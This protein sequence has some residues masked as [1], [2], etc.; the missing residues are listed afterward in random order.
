MARVRALGS[1]FAFLLRLTALLLGLGLIIVVQRPGGTNPP[2]GCS[3]YCSCVSMLTA[4]SGAHAGDP[5]E[6]ATGSLEWSQTD[7]SV[8]G[9]IP[10]VFRR[11]HRTKDFSAGPFGP[12]TCTNWD[13]FIIRAVNAPWG[14]HVVS[15]GNRHALFMTQQS[16]GMGNTW[17]TCGGQAAY[18]GAKLVVNGTT[19]AGTLTFPSGT[20]FTFAENG[21]L[22]SVRN[23]FGHGV[24]VGRN[25]DGYVTS[26]SNTLNSW[27]INVTYGANGLVSSVS[28]VPLGRT[29]HYTYGAYDCLET[30]QDVNGGVTSHVWVE[31][32]WG[33]GGSG[34]F[35][36]YGLTRVT[37]PRG[38]VI[39][40]NTYAD[41]RVVSQELANGGEYQ[42]QYLT[43]AENYPVRHVTDP[44]GNVTTYRMQICG[45]GESMRIW[46]VTNALGRTTTLGWQELPQLVTSVTDFRNRTVSYNWSPTARL[47]SYTRPTVSGGT[48]TTSAAYEPEFQALTSVTN[49]LNQTTSLTLNAQKLPESIA[50]PWGSAAQLAWSGIGELNSYTPPWGGTYT[51]ERNANG[52]PWR[53]TNPLSEQTTATWDNA[54]RLLTTTDPLLRTVSRAWSPFSRLTSVTGPESTGY[55]LTRNAANMVTR[56]DAA[57]GA[58]HQWTPNGMGETVGWQDPAGASGSIVRDGNGNARVITDRK[59]QKC[60]ITLGPGDRVQQVL[61]RRADGTVESTIDYAYSPTTDLLVSITDSAGPDYSFLYNSLDQVTQISG[62]E[63]ATTVTRDDLGRVTQVQ[64]PGQSAVVYERDTYGRL[65]RVTKGTEWVQYGF[66]AAGRVSTISRSNGIVTTR[67]FDGLS[68]L[69]KIEHRKNGNLLEYEDYARD[70]GGRITARDRNGVNSTFTHNTLDRLTGYAI[71]GQTG[72]FTFSLAG[73]RTGQT[74]NGTPKTLTFNTANRILTDGALAVT[75]DANGA[76]TQYGTAALTWNARHELVQVVD[77]GTTTQFFYDCFGR[78]VGKSVNGALTRYVYLGADLCAEADASWNQTAAYF[79]QPGV[80]RPITRTDAAGT[81]WYLQDLSGSVSALAKN[82]GTLYGRYHYSPWGEVVSADA[83]MPVQP[84][85][86]TARELDN[87]GL[88]FLRSRY[89]LAST[90]RFLS[91][92]GIGLAGGLNLYVFAHNSP[93]GMRDPFG[94][95]NSWGDVDWLQEA[96]DFFSGMGSGVSFGLTDVIQDWMGTGDYVNRDSGAYFVGSLIGDAVNDRLTGGMG[97]ALD[98]GRDMG[99]MGGAAAGFMGGGS[100]WTGQSATAIGR[101][102]DLRRFDGTDVDTWRKTGRIPGPGD[103]PVSWE[104]NKAWLDERIARGDTFYI[105]TD[106]TTLGTGYIPGV[107]NGWFTR[108]ELDYLER[109]GIEVIPVY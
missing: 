72:S 10:M 98:F 14:Y 27:A 93:V 78:R 89:Y 23:R 54:G 36:A 32:V 42:F 53:W 106:P 61:Y 69:D 95:D 79:Y 99:R 34:A 16:D 103:R 104:E 18:A 81:V 31:N 33:T 76:V 12:G 4:G 68:R 17:W 109:Q 77:G 83:G 13:T 86:W 64:A 30:V 80:D 108:L 24:N 40:E 45:P 101:M 92:D 49:E 21:G 75:H 15:P 91:E 82:D 38:V 43:D 28:D 37:D 22:A 41:G 97:D 71:P 19:L 1:R 107:P 105:A 90:G 26:V 67:F 5:V 66:D 63:G 48:A 11:M 46:Q 47:L 2:P 87:T 29:V 20:V 3:F 59:G 74:V 96:T 39:L 9:P 6:L 60:E 44:N 7:L 84:L 62:P 65:Y 52:L 88:Y 102:E 8:G 25:A 70:A 94:F 51:V 55:S 35:L 73:N 50:A 58:A 85:K 56:L 57:G 100:P